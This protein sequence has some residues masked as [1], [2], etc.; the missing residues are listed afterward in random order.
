[1]EQVVVALDVGGSSIKHGLVSLDGQLVGAPG[2]APINS[3]GEAMAIID[4]LATVVRADKATANAAGTSVAGIGIAF[5]GPFDYEKGICYIRGVGKYENLYGIHVG[6]AL[7]SRLHPA[8]PPIRFRND[9]EAALLG[10]A[11]WGVGHG[12]QRVLGVTLGTGLGS[13]FLIRGEPQSAGQGIPPHGWLYA[14]RAGNATADTLFSTRGLQRRLHAATGLESTLEEHAAATRAGNLPARHA[15][16]AFGR[17]LG[18][19]LAPYARD[20]AADLVLVLGGIC[21]AYDLFGASLVAALP[22]PAA[23]GALGRAAALLGV[24]LLFVSPARE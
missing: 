12:V 18:H 3:T 24:S 15:F 14:E 21:G 23:R 2:E 1:V 6:D 4:S 19:F 17:E 5:P 16:A 11:R 8:A 22:V 7:H 9:A 20:F 10:E 13:A